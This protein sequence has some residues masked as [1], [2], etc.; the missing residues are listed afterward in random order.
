VHPGEASIRDVLELSLNHLARRTVKDGIYTSN[1]SYAEWGEVLG[2]NVLASAVL[3][4]TLHHSLTVN[5]KGESYRL[6]ARWKAGSAYPPPA[7]TSDKDK[8]EWGR[9]TARSG[10]INPPDLGNCNRR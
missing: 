3:D 4:R 6:Q 10:E 9:M 5:I 1:K 7:R 8:L 2:D